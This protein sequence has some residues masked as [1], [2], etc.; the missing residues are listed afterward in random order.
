MLSYLEKRY[1][2]IF[3]LNQF[4]PVRLHTRTYL[5]RAQELKRGLKV[6]VFSP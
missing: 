2:L 4:E 1:A 3:E 6:N 5:Q